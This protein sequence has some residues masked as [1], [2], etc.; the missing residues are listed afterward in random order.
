MKTL[1]SRSAPA[2]AFG[3]HHEKKPVTT[4]PQPKDDKPAATEQAKPARR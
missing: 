2:A 3:C 1:R 4:I